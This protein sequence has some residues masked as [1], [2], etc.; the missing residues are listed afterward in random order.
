MTTGPTTDEALAENLAGW[1]ERARLHVASYDAESFADD[2]QRIELVVAAS[3]RLMGPHL[4]GGSVSGLDVVHLQCHIGTDSISLARLGADVTGV[5]FSGEAV[6]IATAL[7]G[8]AGLAHKARFAQARVEDAPDAL[9]GKQFDVVYTSVGVL[10]WLPDLSQWA[11]AVGA[12]LKPGGLFFILEDHPMLDALDWDEGQ[13]RFVTARAYFH[14]VEPETWDDGQDYSS[15]VPLR[16]KRS[17]EW[18]HH[19][20][21]TITALLEAGLRIEALQEHQT[22]YW[23]AND[24]L[25]P[26]GVPG[27]WALR[28]NPERVPLMFSIAARKAL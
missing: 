10:R 11:D 4:P 17:H 28:D 16:N 25:T 3:A 15:P 9:D 7:A 2:P 6:A 22:M 27:E 19:L 23:Q 24:A 5:D 20:S 26:T 12:L 13:G 14:Q 21:E 1:D 8:R 18:A